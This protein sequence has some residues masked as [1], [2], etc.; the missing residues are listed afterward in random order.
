MKVQAVTDVGRERGINQDYV[1]YSLT[2]VGSLP[3]LFIV[4]D[5]MGGHKAGDMAS[6]YTVETFVSVAKKSSAKNPISIINNAVT[7]V[8]KMLLDKAKESPDYEGMGTTLVV[9]TVYDNVLKVANVGDSRLYV[10]GN[11]ITQVTR[12]HSLVEEMVSLGEIKREEARTHSQ[13]NIITRAIGGYET[14]DAEMFSVDLKPKDLILMCSDGLSNMVEDSEIL[15]IVKTSAD[16]E[17]AVEK[18]V[19]TANDNGGRDNITVM[20]IEP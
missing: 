15:R 12:D 8:N 13:K 7:Q 18:L 10:I 6:R 16:I 9:A 14:V 4:A 3:N 1:F 5:G 19:K 11:D 2:E 17:S 20:I